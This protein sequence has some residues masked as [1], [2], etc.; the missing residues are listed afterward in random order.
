MSI[1]HPG[2]FNWLVYRIDQPN[3]GMIGD[4][5][6][7]KGQIEAIL[8]QALGTGAESAGFPLPVWH[9]VSNGL[10][11]DP[12]GG[13]LDEQTTQN[14]Q[15]LLLMWQSLGG[16]RVSIELVYEGPN[17]PTHNWTSFDVPESPK[18]QDGTPQ[19][20]GWD[21]LAGKMYLENLTL[22]RYLKSICESSGLPYLLDISPEWNT[23]LIAGKVASE[24]PLFQFSKR[25]WTDFTLLEGDKANGNHVSFATMSADPDPSAALHAQDVFSNNWPDVL[26]FHIYGATNSGY[27]WGSAYS[28]FLE[29]HMECQTQDVPN[30]PFRIGE[31]L[32]DLTTIKELVRASNDTG[33]AIDTILQWEQDEQDISANV[34]PRDFSRFK[35]LGA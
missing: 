7:G 17:D 33:R 21:Q 12:T 18:N 29:M 14:L 2:G 3:K 22:V 6:N 23:N 34:V 16:K 4:F 25:I 15:N 26:D 30:L 24:E 31:T 11:C 13:K 20:P 28:V 35:L 1:L 32:N 19:Y 27:Y 10:T 8:A 5:H 9:G